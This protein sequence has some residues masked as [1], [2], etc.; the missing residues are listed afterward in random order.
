VPVPMSFGQNAGSAAWDLDG[1]DAAVRQTAP[2]A[3]Y[4]I[5]DFQNPAGALMS[6]ADRGR[7]ASL[8]QRSRTLVVV[9]ETL[10]ELGL[11]GVEAR[12]FASFG[13]FADAGAVTVGSA[14]KVFWG[15]LRVGWLRSDAAT[16]QVPVVAMTASVM[17]EDRERFDKAGFDGFITKP[18][19]VR[20]FPQQVRDH[21][22]RGRV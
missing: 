22:A 15:G 6:A 18:I 19:D 14:S 16:A 2:R 21:V 4:L 13:P 8:M 17:R 10:V 5:P 12:P 9:D 3:A 11:D 7:V 1:I 20:T